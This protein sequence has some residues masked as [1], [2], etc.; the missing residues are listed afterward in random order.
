MNSQ[1]RLALRGMVLLIF[2]LALL[3]WPAWSSVDARRLSD[4]RARVGDVES[5]QLSPDGSRALYLADQDQAGVV[6]L[7]SVPLAGGPATKLNS[8]TDDERPVYEAKISPDGTRVIFLAGGTAPSPAGLFSVPIDGGAP[9]RINRSADRAV[10][11]GDFEISADG[12]HVVYQSDELSGR[13]ELYSVP[14]GGGTITNL[15]SEVPGPDGQVE[16]FAISPDGRQVVYTAFRLTEGISD[17]FIVAIEGGV[18]ERLNTPPLRHVEAFAFALAGNAVV[19]EVRLPTSS[20]SGLFS[21]PLVGGSSQYLSGSLPEGATPQGFAVTPDGRRVVFRAGVYGAFEQGLYSVEVAT[22]ELVTLADPALAVALDIE[23]SPDSRFAIFRGRV[24]GR[25]ALF[26]ASVAGGPSLRLSGLGQ[27]GTSVAD[28]VISPNGRHVVFVERAD[29]QQATVLRSVSMNGGP[30]VQLST[31]V[32]ISLGLPGVR[33]SA[34]SQ[35]VVY[36]AADD[37]AAPSDLMR[38]AIRGGPATRLNAPLRE[39]SAVRPSFVLSPDGTNVVYRA[40]QEEQDV[41]ELFVASTAAGDP[42]RRLNDAMIAIGGRIVDAQLSTRTGRAIYLANRRLEGLMELLSVDLASGEIIRLD[43]APDTSEGVTAFELTPQEDRAIFI[44]QSEDFGSFDAWSV[45][46]GGGLPTHLSG[47]FRTSFGGGGRVRISPDGRWLVYLARLD[48]QGS[49][50]LFAVPTDGSADAVQLSSSID[51]NG[52]NVVSSLQISPDSRYVLY[53]RFDGDLISAP[54]SPAAGSSA[55]EGEVQLTNFSDEPGFLGTVTITPDS[56]RAIVNYRPAG[57]QNEIYSVPTT[58]GEPVRLSADDASAAFAVAIT[59]DSQYLIYR[60]DRDGSF[61]WDVFRVPITGGPS[62]MLNQRGNGHETVFASRLSPDGRHV[63]FTAVRSGT[64]RA[65]LLR[66]AVEGGEIVRLDGALGAS[67]SSFLPAFTPDGRQV[68]FLHTTEDDARALWSVPLEGGS[69]TRLDEPGLPLSLVERFWIN[70]NGLSVIY[71]APQED[72]QLFG[73]FHVP[74][75]GGLVTPLT[76]VGLGPVPD[77]GAGRP[78]GSLNRGI[79]FADD[80]LAAIFFAPDPS[81]LVD[82]LWVVTGFPERLRLGPPDLMP[83]GQTDGPGS[84]APGLGFY[85]GIR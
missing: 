40:D 64:S 30:I 37:D 69:L 20:I 21:A 44:S 51:E 13:Q 38:I 25:N 60:A 73:L 78:A 66:V 79:T 82:D 83:T 2:G 15:S 10:T 58:G 4:L 23:L 17:L 26:R 54:I 75:V 62:T 8:P 32:L 74:I 76:T 29:P 39:G 59:P 65:S 81:T 57:V 61:D 11:V 6:E 45:P 77:P 33:I 36:L 3:P 5:V 52:R 14:L 56:T 70:P 19:Y 41:V 27:P 16:R 9:I 46:V 63:L 67:G 22:G 71:Q 24:E 72:G 80:G 18:A 85:K 34:D 28:F 49:N 42:P 53:R 84:G 55:G 1:S 7:Y 43:A 47:P 35:H 12:Q 50:D 48:G 68:A 31:S